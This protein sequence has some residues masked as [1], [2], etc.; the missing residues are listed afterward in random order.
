MILSHKYRFIFLKTHKTAGTSVEISLSRY[1]G[2]ADIITPVWEEDEAIRR[3]HDCGPQNHQ[4]RWGDYSARDLLRL[5]VKRRPKAGLKFYNHMPAREVR[6]LVGERVWNSY[7]KFCFERNPWDKVIS[8]F[9]F[10]NQGRADFDDFVK[11][12]TLWSDHELYT[13]DGQ[14]AV[15][16]VGSYERLAGEL[17]RICSRLQIPFDGWLPRAKG[18]YRRDRRPYGEVYTPEQVARV[19]ARFAREIELFGY[20][21]EA[22]AC[23]SRNVNGASGSH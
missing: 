17:E 6:R 23:V 8:Q 4:Y 3:E 21:F 22:P 2:P 12:A 19:A 7:F 20:T 16:H 18:Q 5:L 9:C 15:D 13:I 14:L 10:D 11:H 1:C